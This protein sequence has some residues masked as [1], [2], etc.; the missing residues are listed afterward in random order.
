MNSNK[1]KD[2]QMAENSDKEPKKL[3]L[4]AKGTLS[5]KAPVGPGGTS[6]QNVAM[7]RSHKPVAVEVKKKRGAHAESSR[8]AAEE[9]F[10]D[11]HL[12][13]AEREARQ[14]AVNQAK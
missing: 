2:N 9:A 10:Q 7:G 5:L 14:R 1:A 8:Q 13:D 4:S 6:R 3:S 12:T 11:L